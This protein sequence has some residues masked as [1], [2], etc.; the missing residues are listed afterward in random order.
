[1]ECVWECG[2]DFLFVISY[3]QMHTVPAMCV[4]VCLLARLL[5]CLLESAYWKLVTIQ[6]L[7]WQ[8]LCC[9]GF[10]QVNWYP[11]EI[12]YLL[13]YVGANYYSYT[14]AESIGSLI[15]I[16]TCPQSCYTTDGI[17]DHLR[18]SMLGVLQ[19]FGSLNLCGSV[20][21]RARARV[22]VRA[23]IN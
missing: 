2:Y 17:S 16:I 1:M 10:K 13:R 11:L 5:V 8:C 22:R 18:N 23:I 12:N 15:W 14:I 6:L 7:F 20:W 9:W 21:V 3:K 19:S 4:A